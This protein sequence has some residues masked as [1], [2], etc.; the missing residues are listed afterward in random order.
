MGK[1][2]KNIR[3]LNAIKQ[4]REDAEKM[5]CFNV[6]KQDDLKLIGLVFDDLSLSHLTYM[7][8][9]SINKLCRDYVGID[10]VVFSTNIT[11][12][13][14]QLLCPMLNTSD[15]IRWQTYPLITTSINTTI[16]ALDSRAENIYHYVFDPYLYNLPHKESDEIIPAFCD[17]R[18][19]IITRH[20]DH[21]LLI[22]REFDIKTIEIIIPDCNVL[23][24]AK[25]ILSEGNK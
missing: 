6:E 3:K 16:K 7:G 10:I 21:K 17:P 5:S 11:P 4:Q 22:E 2:Q 1:K 19:K 13:C 23:M 24:L 20:E 14:I 8:I 18:V 15:L 9:T 12:P 25:L